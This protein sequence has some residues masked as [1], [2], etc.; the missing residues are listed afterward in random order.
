[1]DSDYPLVASDFSLES[2]ILKPLFKLLEPLQLFCFIIC[3]HKIH[4]INNYVERKYLN[5]NWTFYT[6]K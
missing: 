1:M 5:C 4:R 6:T 2:V 3:K